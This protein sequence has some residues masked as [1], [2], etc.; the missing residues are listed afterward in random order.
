[1]IK[2]TMIAKIRD[3]RIIQP[4]RS[5]CPLPQPS[6]PLK[7]EVFIPPLPH[8]FSPTTADQQLARAE[9]GA[10]LREMITDIV[11]L[12][13]P[14]T[15]VFHFPDDVEQFSVR[16]RWSFEWDGTTPKPI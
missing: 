15:R 12:E 6:L 2:L 13:F 7:K 14:S 10:I 8:G 11:V 1:M 16:L 9:T 5:V 3:T 4:T